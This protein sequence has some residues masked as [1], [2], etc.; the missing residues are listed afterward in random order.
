METYLVHH[1]ILGQKWGKK[2][3][4]PYPLDYSKLSAEERELA[5]ADA[6][7]RGDV[8][9]ASYNRQYYTDKELEAV[10]NRYNLN[11]KLNSITAEPSKLDKFVATGQKMGQVAD[12]VGKGVNLYNHIAKITNAF[13]GSELPVVGE[14]KNDNNNNGNNNN[15]KSN[16]NQ[17]NN[18]KKVERSYVDGKLIE[19]KKFK[20]NGSSSERTWDSEGNLTKETTNKRKANGD[21]VVTRNKYNSPKEPGL[22]KSLW[23]EDKAALNTDMKTVSNKTS[24]SL[25]KINEAL[26]SL[27]STQS[28]SSQKAKNNADL[29]S[30][31]KELLKKNDDLLKKKQNSFHFFDRPT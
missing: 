3:G 6:T 1:G 9:E 13:T 27:P 4:P 21:M 2:N 24:D 11:A 12:A 30:L 19:E 20:R 25:M 17:N 28:K 5:K 16:N 8:K 29:D 23:E 10:I 7:R 14:K 15:N 31:N 18:P 22:V 26:F